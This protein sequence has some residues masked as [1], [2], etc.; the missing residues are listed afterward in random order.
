MTADI[1][2]L[3]STIARIARACPG[4]GKV[5]LFKLLYLIDFTAHARLGHSVTGEMYESFEMG[6]VPVTLWKRFNDITR[7][8]VRVEAVPTSLGIAEQ[9]MT[10]RDGCPERLVPE[11][12]G[13]VDEIMRRFGNYSGNGLRELTH[14]Q[15]PY[16]ATSRGDAIPYG[17]AGYLFFRRP[18]HEEAAAIRADVALMEDI[19]AAVLRKQG[20]TA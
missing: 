13:I 12:A 15:V 3:R 7:E 18:T 10:A 14:K 16:L 19:R 9:Q 5:K 17:L 8:C 2:K 1:E 11:E 20:A 6:P 4:L